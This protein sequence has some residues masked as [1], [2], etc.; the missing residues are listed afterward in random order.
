MAAAFATALVILGCGIVVWR[1]G[2]LGGGDVKLLTALS[3]WA[4]PFHTPALLLATA[5]NGGA[6]ALLCIALRHPVV[7][8]GLT[9]LQV[10]CQ[11][12]LRS[13]DGAGSTAKPAQVPGAAATNSLPYGVAV[14]AAGC[15]LLQRLIVT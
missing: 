12:L 8:P 2:W 10:R 4:G 11:S 5:L 14:A 13:P 9:M 6:L 3:L 7:M 1:L 15:W